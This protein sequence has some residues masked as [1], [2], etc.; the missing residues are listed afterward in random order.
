MRRGS[1]P[2]SVALALI[3]TGAEARWKER[4]KDG[5]AEKAKSGKRI[6]EV[7]MGSLHQLLTL[8][9]SPELL[10]TRRIPSGHSGESFSSALKTV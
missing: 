7:L 5:V 2:G 6:R 1:D 10:L 9:D 8:I 3:N 4:E